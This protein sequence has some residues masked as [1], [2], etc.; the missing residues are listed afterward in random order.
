MNKV[1][2]IN[3]SKEAYQIET[4]YWRL[5]R[6]RQVNACEYSASTPSWTATDRARTRSTTSYSHW[7]KDSIT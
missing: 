3:I 2:K 5:K 7:T 1:P 6:K 4:T